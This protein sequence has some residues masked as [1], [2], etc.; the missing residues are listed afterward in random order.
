MR[1]REGARLAATLKPTSGGSVAPRLRVEGVA[2]GGRG[3]VVRLHGEARG[4][5]ALRLVRLELLQWRDERRRERRTHVFTGHRIS[6]ACGGGEERRKRRKRDERSNA[7]QLI[8]THLNPALLMAK[9]AQAEENFFFFF[10]PIKAVSAGRKS[11]GL[12]Q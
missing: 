11:G 6:C 3:G 8:S 1:G 2:G 12:P 5:V 9:G 10:F 4:G 7:T